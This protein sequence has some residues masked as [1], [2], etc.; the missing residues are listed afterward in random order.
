MTN[1]G[2]NNIQSDQDP[3]SIGELIT[4]EE[5]AEYAGLSKESIHSYV[6]KGRLKA[7]KE[8]GCGS[9]HALLLMNT[10]DLGISKISP[11]NI[12]KAIDTTLISV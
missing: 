1:D 3:L 5:A 2:T 9:R 4:L 10:S 6:K 8:A 12:E 11:R 7:K